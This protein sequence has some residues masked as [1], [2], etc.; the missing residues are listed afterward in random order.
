MPRTVFAI[1]EMSMF[2]VV[3]FGTVHYLV[4]LKKNFYPRIL[5]EFWRGDELWLV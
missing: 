4:L 3:I 2:I 5:N 1:W